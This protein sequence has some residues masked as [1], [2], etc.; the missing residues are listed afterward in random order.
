MPLHKAGQ[1]SGLQEWIAFK[2]FP[3]LLR[4]VFSLRR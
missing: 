4:G 2:A 3:L 1:A